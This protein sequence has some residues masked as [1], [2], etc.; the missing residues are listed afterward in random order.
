MNRTVRE[1]GVVNDAHIDEGKDLTEKQETAIQSYRDFV[2]VAEVCGHVATLSVE[3]AWNAENTSTEDG[4]GKDQRKRANTPLVGIGRVRLWQIDNRELTSEIAIWKR[5]FARGG[6]DLLKGSGMLSISGNA[7]KGMG[8]S[9]TVARIARESEQ[10]RNTP[11]PL[12]DPVHGQV[13]PENAP[14][15]GGSNWAGGT[16]GS[17]TAGLGG[18]GGPYRLDAGHSQYRLS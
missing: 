9:E 1:I 2:A 17:N 13:D 11:P 3:Q 8:V 7:L 6:E 5:M 18:R 16:G 15:V 14:H 4:N 10:R 12:K